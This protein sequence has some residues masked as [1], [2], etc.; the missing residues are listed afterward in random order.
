M[1]MMQMKR[2]VMTKKKMKMMIENCYDYQYH[3]CKRHN[4]LSQSWE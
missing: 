1:M 4:Y 3:C 2:I